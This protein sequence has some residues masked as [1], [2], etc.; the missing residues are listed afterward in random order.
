MSKEIIRELTLLQSVINAIPTPL[1]FKDSEGVYLGCNQ[2]FEEFV[3]KT[4]DQLIGRGVFELWETSLAQIYFDADAALIQSG[5]KQVYEAQVKYA[6]GILRDVLFHKSVFYAQT[7]NISGLVGVLVDVTERKR[8]EE[9]LEKLAT[10]DALTGLYNRHHLYEALDAACKRAKRYGSHLAVLFLDLDGFKAINDAQG[11]AVGDLLLIEVARVLR[12]SVRE[13]D[14]VARFGGDEFVI[15]T[16]SRDI[17][18]EQPEPSELIAQKIID[19][20]GQPFQIQGETLTIG[21]SIG[22]ARY[23]LNGGD[24]QSLIKHADLGLYEAKARGKGQYCNATRET[25]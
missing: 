19:R 24:P 3:G 22:I 4:R 20:L 12:E 10:T 17:G 1:F 5:G 18:K 23:S 25:Q 15:V 9:K 6:D 8:A 2:A 14:L 11:H 7:E 21:A 16:E 13:M